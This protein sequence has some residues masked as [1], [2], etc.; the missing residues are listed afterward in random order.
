MSFNKVKTT[1]EFMKNFE[2]FY[3]GL[4]SLTCLHDSHRK[5]KEEMKEGR[6]ANFRRLQFMISDQ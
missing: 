1:I 4:F 6:H 5:M 3:F 2:E